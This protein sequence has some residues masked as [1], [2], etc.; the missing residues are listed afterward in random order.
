MIATHINYFIVTPRAAISSPLPLSHLIA[1]LA[2]SFDRQAFDRF[3]QLANRS[4]LLKTPIDRQILL[5]N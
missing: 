2:Q 3:S 4:P 1:T 5:V